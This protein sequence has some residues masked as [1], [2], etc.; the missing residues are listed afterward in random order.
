MTS[1]VIHIK[2]RPVP[3]AWHNPT[4]IVHY[5]HISMHRQGL[6]IHLVR[7]AG[8]KINGPDKSMCKIMALYGN[9]TNMAENIS[10]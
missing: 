7:Q 8:S 5:S 1:C 3:T 2:R 4:A 10:T 6:E 9:N